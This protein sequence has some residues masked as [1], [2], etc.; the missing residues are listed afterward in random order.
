VLIPE[1]NAIGTLNAMPRPLIAN[2]VAK[3]IRSTMAIGDRKTMSD[4]MKPNLAPAL[5]PT[6]ALAV[7]TAV[8]RYGNASVEMQTL[9]LETIAKGPDGAAARKALA[10]RF[11][12][13]NAVKA[14]V[15]QTGIKSAAAA[16]E[17]S[18]PEWFAQL[19]AALETDAARGGGYA[20]FMACAVEVAKGGV[21]I[22]VIAEGW[23]LNS[24]ALEELRG[25]VA[26]ATPAEPMKIERK[27][28]PASMKAAPKPE[29]KPVQLPAVASARLHGEIT[30]PIA[31]TAHDQV[32]LLNQKHSVIGNYGGKC[33]VL[34]WERWE[35]NEGV[36][37]PTF[38]TFGDFQNR[39][40]NRY[41]QKQTDEGVKNISAGNFWLAAPDRVTYDKA[42]FEP[43]E[44]EVLSGNRLN[45]WRGFAVEPRK[46][47][48]RLLRRHIYL[49]LGG[50]DWKAGRYIIRWLAW[51][52]QNPGR[53]AEAVLAFQ[54]D[55]GAGKGTL[56]RVMLQ[57]FGSASLPI[58][59]PNMLAGQFSGHLHHCVFLFVDEAFW[60]GDVRAEGRL[61]SLI[62]EPT[63]TIRPMYVQG[64]QVRNM[65]H[66]M[67][68]SN[69]DWVV[70]AGH[71]AR[72]Y[73][74]FKVGDERLCDFAYFD[75]LNREING[76]GTEAMLY[77][78]LRLDLGDWHPKRIYVTTAL[79]EQKGHSL[80]GLDAWIESL[81]QE[82]ALPKPVLNYPNRCL[83]EDLLAAAKQ[84]DRYTNKSA[85]AGK[86]KKVLGEARMKDFNNKVARGWIFPPLDECRQTWER[87]NGG[88]WRWHRNVDEW[89]RG[90]AV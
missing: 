84:F 13:A 6:A 62:T 50:G 63:I 14:G 79:T 90:T 12:A 43:G 51:M 68:S 40:K 67:M 37:I 52:L 9:A 66:I 59:D 77:D 69:N 11:A 47:S 57:I 86:L 3:M 35:I 23:G 83:S 58:S 39:Y 8:S 26:K 4:E 18:E 21:S 36:M 30:L 82:G 33:M 65:L 42:V 20:G 28:L 55:E 72:R 10:A 7:E 70:P 22:E 46:G 16:L 45:L 54:G 5:S 17:P 76:G 74:V 61:K 15:E 34:S 32:K 49:V 75:A 71:G 29:V 2:G 27:P 56:A 78:L 25:E 41:V 73:A 89:Q 31:A 81:L 64:F 85:I 87:R 19:D 38:Q 53:P 44:P 88:T 1:L 24:V 60:A 48:W 80:R